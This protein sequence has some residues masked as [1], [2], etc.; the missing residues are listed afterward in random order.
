M[1][2]PHPE[3]Q[4]RARE[5]K[6]IRGEAQADSGEDYERSTRPREAKPSPRGKADS[7]RGKADSGARPNKTILPNYL[8]R[9]KRNLN[10]M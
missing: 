2:S 1:G 4:S 9:L 6:P 8:M 5:A 3:R 7:G 10:Y